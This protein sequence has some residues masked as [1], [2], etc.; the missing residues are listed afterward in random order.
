M[1]TRRTARAFMVVAGL[2]VTTWLTGC[3]PVAA[4]APQVCRDVVH[5][6]APYTVCTID[7]K[8]HD[9][10]LALKAPHGDN[11]GNLGSFARAQAKAGRPVTVAMNAGMYH[12]DGRPVGLYVEDGKEVQKV[13]TA[14]GPGNFHLLPNG[15]FFVTAK[16]A[17]V[18]ETQAYLRQ[19]PPAVFATQSGPMLVIDGKLHP[20]FTADGPSQKVR[21]GVGIRD[22][23]TVVF[24]ISND[25]VSFGAFGRLF[26]D[27]LKCP[28][29]LYLDGSISSLWAPGTGRADELWPVGPIV[30]AV[31]KAP[32]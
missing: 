6:G 30:A 24:A 1:I 4:K 20:R 21:N 5:E 7:L 14:R 25:A 3:G 22:A 31:P 13:S 16:G 28:N 15:V 27:T 18:L 29:A 23:S 11:W 26:R 2:T 10:R 32:R 19:K 12:A 17:G 8:T 9:L